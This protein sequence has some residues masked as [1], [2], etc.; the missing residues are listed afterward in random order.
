VTVHHI[1]STSAPGIHAKPIIDLLPVVRDL[2]EFDRAQPVMERLGFNWHGEFGLP[3]RRYNTRDD[4]QTGRR[5]IQAHCYAAGNPE[6]DRHVA[7]RDYLRANPAEAQAYDAEKARCRD[8]CPDSSYDYND[9][10]N[11]F[12][13]AM[14]QE[15]LRAWAMGDR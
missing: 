6:I 7:F 9:C 11:D 14:E 8:L 3:G 15:A 13:K 1:G 4:P 2:E 10:K 12:V 5:L